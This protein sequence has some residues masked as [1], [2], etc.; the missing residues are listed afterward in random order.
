MIIINPFI[1]IGGQTDPLKY[2]GVSSP[3]NLRMVDVTD[4]TMCETILSRDTK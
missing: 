4:L 2:G 3:Y 1:T